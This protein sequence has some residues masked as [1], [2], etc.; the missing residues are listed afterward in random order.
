MR[1][2]IVI[3]LA[4]LITAAAKATLSL[5]KRQDREKGLELNEKSYSLSGIF[6]LLFSKKDR[7][8]SIET[9]SATAAYL[10]ENPNVERRFYIL[11]G[12]SCVFVLMTGILAYIGGCTPVPYA[13]S[14]VLLLI[15]MVRKKDACLSL[16][17]A[18]GIFLFMIG[19]LFQTGI[20][21][22]LL[23]CHGTVIADRILM[24]KERRTIN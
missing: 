24:T 11:G 5:I 3:I 17:I 1:I 4:A 8:L 23:L 16:S 20:Y 13:L 6:R 12:I 7:R 9:R 21:L 22:I 19:I 10:R 2:Q 15:Y 14:L 18:T